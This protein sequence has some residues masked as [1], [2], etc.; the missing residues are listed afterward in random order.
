MRPG[1]A[2]ADPAQQD[3]AFQGGTIE[4]DYE[5]LN[6]AEGHGV[7]SMK[8]PRTSVIGPG[9]SAFERRTRPGLALPNREGF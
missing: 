1:L 8:G 6:R 5:H 2:E 3:L 4:L 7:L 9:S